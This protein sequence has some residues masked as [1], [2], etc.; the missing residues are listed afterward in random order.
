M[1]IQPCQYRLKRHRP[2]RLSGGTWWRSEGYSEDEKR[3]E[4]TELS[5]DVNCIGLNMD[6]I[7]GKRLGI[8]YATEASTVYI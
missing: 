7:A 2:P 6:Y 1:C 8:E 4:E 5:K 3:G